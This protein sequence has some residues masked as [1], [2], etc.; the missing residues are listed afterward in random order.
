MSQGSDFASIPRHE[1]VATALQLGIERPDAL[2]AEE[3][4]A[5]IQSHSEGQRADNKAGWFAV[6]RHLV[7]SV[8]EQG[9]NLPAA[10]KV[11]RSVGVR[12][13]TPPSRTRPPLP[14]VTLAQIYLEQRHRDRAR[15]TLEQVIERQPD[16]SKARSLLEQLDREDA[17]AR[18]EEP[19]REVE[20]SEKTSNAESSNGLSESPSATPSQAPPETPVRAAAPAG[21]VVESDVAVQWDDGERVRIAWRLGASSRQLIADE[22]VEL[23]LRTIAPAFPKPVVSELRVSLETPRGEQQLPRHRGAELRVAIVDARGAVLVVAR[24]CETDDGGDVREIQDA[25][26]PT[27]DAR[28]AELLREVR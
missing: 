4:T 22:G 19:S 18:S 5:A 21:E 7:A 28:G 11:I 10:A 9:L 1:L 24:R 16:N 3:L 14:T 12:V 8:V 26:A 13:G 15:V 27:S 25:F 2:T 20:S 6:A 17:L 23:Q